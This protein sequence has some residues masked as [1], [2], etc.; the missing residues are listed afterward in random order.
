MPKENLIHIKL[1]YPEAINAKRGV[2]SSQMRLLKIAK[3]IKEYN[4][5]RNEEIELKS[6]LYKKSKE[7]R[8]NIRKLQS[9]LPKA[10]LPE[11][12][13][14]EKEEKSEKPSRKEKIPERDIEGQLQE[15]QRRL[16]ELQ[17][18]NI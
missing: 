3:S 14:K 16:N 17:E 1:D 7:L 2:L 4:F 5:Y 11:I 12:L 18:K 9:V 10:K 8:L 15:I 13:K 6:L